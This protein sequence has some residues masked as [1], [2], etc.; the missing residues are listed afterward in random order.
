MNYNIVNE[1]GFLMTPMLNR[2]GNTYLVEWLSKVALEDQILDVVKEVVNSALVE[3]Q[4]RPNKSI[5]VFGVLLNSEDLLSL[6][7]NINCI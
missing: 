2:F 1:L 3:A 4:S 5:N 6:T 7:D